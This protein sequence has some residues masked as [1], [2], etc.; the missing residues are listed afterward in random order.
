[1]RESLRNIDAV[2][3]DLDGLVLDSERPIRDAVIEVV[4]ALGFEM[5]HAFYATMIGVPG[6]EC[7]AMVQRYFGPDFPFETYVD[8][9]NARI[10][11]ALSAGIA[12]KAGVLEILGDLETRRMP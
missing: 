11:E 6:P 4:A 7:D 1:M 2:I 8:Q 5:P 9:S 10:A 3:F 12:L